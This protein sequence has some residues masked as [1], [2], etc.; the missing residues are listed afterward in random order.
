[1]PETFRPFSLLHGLVLAVAATTWMVLIGALRRQRAAGRD[2]P[3]RRAI[4]LFILATNLANFAWRWTPERFNLDSSLPLHLCD[5]AW[6]AAAWIFLDRRERQVLPRELLF[7]WG[8]G[9]C[10]QAFVTPTRDDGP[11]RFAF[12]D[13]WISHT[14]ILLGAAYSAFVLGHRPDTRSLRRVLL[15]SWSLYLPISAFNAVFDTPYFFSGRG[16]PSS[17]TVLDHLGPYPWRI[18]SLGLLGS[19]VVVLITLPF[20]LRRS[21]GSARG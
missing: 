5:F 16:R 21:A 2:W 3:L 1:M 14:E 6:M 15:V 17:A 18:L 7:L 11:A 19:G 8:F 10:T 20:L 9:L 13:F 12:W 4:G